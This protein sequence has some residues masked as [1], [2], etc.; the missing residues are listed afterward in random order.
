MLRNEWYQ[1]ASDMIAGRQRELEEIML[2]FFNDERDP[3]Y[4][5]VELESLTVGEIVDWL[6]D[7]KGYISPFIK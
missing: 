3:K 5:L 7:N 6:R 2:E 1:L 4:R